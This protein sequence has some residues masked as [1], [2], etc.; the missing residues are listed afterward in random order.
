MIRYG[1]HRCM[2]VELEDKSSFQWDDFCNTYSHG[3]WWLMT[4]IKFFRLAIHIYSHWSHGTYGRR[5]P[6]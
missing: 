1:P 6:K 3:D 5:V 4:R 2:S